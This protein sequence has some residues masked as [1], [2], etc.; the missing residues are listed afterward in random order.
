MKEVPSNFLGQLS[1]PA[2]RAL[3][4][5]GI[6]SVQKLSTYTEKDILK[7]HGVGKA[8]LP[9][10]RKALEDEGLSFK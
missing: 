8:S 5:Q 2:R 4:H 9:I 3:Q 10:F 7:L 1:S 6:D